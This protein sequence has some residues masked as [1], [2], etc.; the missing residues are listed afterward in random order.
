MTATSSDA[1]VA[2]A[3]QPLSASEVDQARLCLRQAQ[4]AIVGATKGVSDAQATFKPDAQTWSIAE[5]VEHVV[6]VQERVLG[7]MWQQLATAPP[8]PEDRDCGAVDALIIDRFPN[9]LKRFS[10]PET[11]HPKGAFSLAEGVG[12]VVTNTARLTELLDSTPDLR[13][14]ALQAMPLKAMSNGAHGFMDAYQWILAT[15]VHTERH[16]KQILEVKA[17]PNFPAN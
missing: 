14:H 12:R 7:P 6:I 17:H 8:C 4:D 2:T 5:N 16:A 1:P 3:A 10:G 13:Q 9:R 11:V 15:A